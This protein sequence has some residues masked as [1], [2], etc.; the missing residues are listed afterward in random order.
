MR[1]WEESD[2]LRPTTKTYGRGT[3]AE[4]AAWLRENPRRVVKRLNL[5]PVDYWALRNG[6][7]LT[8]RAATGL[9]TFPAPGGLV[10]GADACSTSGSSSRSSSGYR[11]PGVRS[12]PPE[13]GRDARAAHRRR[14]TLRWTAQCTAIRSAATGRRGGWSKAS[15]LRWMV[16]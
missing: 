10:V 3:F 7:S 9:A 12:R 11:W 2:C 13:G 8:L 14:I 4:L 16:G 5:N 15:F 6:A 1:F